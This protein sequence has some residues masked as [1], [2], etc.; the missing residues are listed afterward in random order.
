MHRMCTRICWRLPGFAGLMVTAAPR[1]DN[2]CA[3]LRRAL[4]TDEL[5]FPA[6]GILG[7]WPSSDHG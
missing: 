6:G 5:C 7:G 1:S 3:R 2:L 4:G